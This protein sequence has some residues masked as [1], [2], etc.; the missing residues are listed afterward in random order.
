MINEPMKPRLE[1]EQPIDIYTLIIQELPKGAL[2]K[3]MPRAQPNSAH[4]NEQASSITA[5]R[6][7]TAKVAESA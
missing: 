5:R 7:R 1:H 4:N 6:S 3:S 2:T